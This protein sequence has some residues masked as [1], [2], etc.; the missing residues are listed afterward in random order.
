M[1]R[2]RRWLETRW[3]SINIPHLRNPNGEGE[4]VKA[5]SIPASDET[6]REVFQFWETAPK[7]RSDHGSRGHRWSNSEDDLIDRR[8]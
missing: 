6:G 7:P 2:A 5:P 3:G 8:Q 1:A 4:T